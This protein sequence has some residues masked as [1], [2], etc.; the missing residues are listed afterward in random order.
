VKIAQIEK[1]LS[2]GGQTQQALLLAKGLKELGINSSI[3]CQPGSIISLRSKEE[4]L[5]TFEL[6][7]KGSDLFLSIFS[8]RRILKGERIDIIHA[9]SP[10]AHLLAS[11]SCMGTS[12]KVVRTKHNVNPIKGSIFGKIQ[13][14][15]MTDRLVAVSEEVK[16]QMVSDGIPPE[17]IEVVYN[18]VEIGRFDP[19]RRHEEIQEEFHLKG[20]KVVGSVMRL[21]PSKGI[22]TLIESIGAVAMKVQDVKFLIAGKMGENRLWIERE[23]MRRGIGQWVVFSDFRRD[24]PSIL[25]VMDIF[26]LPSLREGLGSS[27]LEAMAMGKPVIASCVGGIPE[28][29][30]HGHTGL[31]VPPGDAFELSCRI[32]ELLSDKEKMRKMGMEGRKRV[33]ELFSLEKMVKG[34]LEIYRDLI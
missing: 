27:I 24:I 28:V 4:G 25:S 8:L 19:D 26:V 33:E 10:R 12:T 13:Y 1:Q 14:G 32:V 31:L 5:K 2:W 15:F 17:M 30:V 3:I 22:M 11:L 9:H 16:R 7:M 29:V 6:P 21:H 34:N 18:G 20:R 23:V